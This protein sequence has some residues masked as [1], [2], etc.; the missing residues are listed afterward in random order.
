MISEYHNSYLYHGTDV[1]FNIPKLS[2]SISGKDFGKGFYL[3]TE[4]SQAIRFS[5]TK[6]NKNMGKSCYLNKYFFF[7]FKNL[8]VLEFK[9]ANSNWFNCVIDNRKYKSSKWD[10][11]DVIIG[12]IADDATALVI[13]AYLQGAYGPIDSKKAKELAIS[14]LRTENLKE[15]LCFKSE[16]ALDMLAYVNTEEVIK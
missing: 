13:N 5:K 8:K 1:R 9:D 4:K 3:T 10:D 12:K 14:L 7:N 6:S 16:K 11:Y 15:Q 2:K